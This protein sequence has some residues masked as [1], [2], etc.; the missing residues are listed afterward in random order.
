MHLYYESAKFKT[1]NENEY[2]FRAKFAAKHLYIQKIAVRDLIAEVRCIK[3]NLIIS[4]DGATA[5]HRKIRR[6]LM[7]QYN[8]HNHAVDVAV[9]NRISQN[10]QYLPTDRFWLLNKLLSN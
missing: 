8:I 1:E 7:K 9:Q 10:S 5:L 4:E 2:K 3:N 6:R